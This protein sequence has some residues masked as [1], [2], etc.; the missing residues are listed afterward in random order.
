M[1]GAF[2]TWRGVLVIGC[3][4]TLSE[5][6][7]AICACTGGGANGPNTL[8]SSSLEPTFNDAPADG[9]GYDSTLRDAPASRNDGAMNDDTT[10]GTSSDA[11]SMDGAASDASACPLFDGSL[12][13]QWIDAGNALIGQFKCNECHGSGLTGNNDSIVDSGLV[14]APNLTPDPT[15]GLGCWS[16]DQVEQAI[17]D[18]VDNQDGALCQMPHFRTRFL[19]AGI[20]PQTGAAQIAGLLRSLPPRQHTVPDTVCPAGDAG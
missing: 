6:T 1:N 17:L 16:D 7:L 18:G 15:T 19:E 4:V 13:A 14:Y 3:T 2:H 12:D 11:L 5:G 10:M 20:D 9:S 8:D